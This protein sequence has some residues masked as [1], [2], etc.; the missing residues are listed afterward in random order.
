MQTHPSP[1][2]HVCTPIAV[3]QAAEA[4]IAGFEDDS[5]QQGI[6]P[7]LFDLRSAIATT[8][9]DALTIAPRL[10]KHLGDAYPPGSDFAWTVQAYWYR[11][12]TQR[13]HGWPHEPC[14]T[15]V[16]V[17]WYDCNGGLWQRAYPAVT[18]DFGTL[19]E[20]AREGGAA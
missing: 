1:S 4:F 3:L 14:K 8:P 15:F 11:M 12:R 16:R 5:S 20:V 10:Y 7:L 9:S 13:E 6:A 17:N 2:A 18:D 19:M